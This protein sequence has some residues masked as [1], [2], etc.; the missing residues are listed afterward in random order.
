MSKL[1]D[2]WKREKI[3]KDL[4]KFNNRK[5]WSNHKSKIIEKEERL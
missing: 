5:R 1:S 3:S 4:N 2:K